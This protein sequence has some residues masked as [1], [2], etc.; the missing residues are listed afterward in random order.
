ML[1]RPDKRALYRMDIPIELTRRIGLLL[2]GVQAPP[3]ETNVAPAV[4]AT[5]HR[6]PRTITLGQIAPGG[7]GAQHPEDAVQDTA[8]IVGRM[9]GPRFPRWEQRL[10]PLPWGIR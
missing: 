2:K 7:S 6:R 8:V 10:Q 9:A 4:N 1:M 5:G 3:D